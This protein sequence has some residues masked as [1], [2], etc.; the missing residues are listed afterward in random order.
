LTSFLGIYPNNGMCNLRY[1]GLG[2]FTL[3]EYTRS[4]LSQ[5][6]KGE[7][8]PNYGKTWTEERR[9]KH[10][11]TWKKKRETGESKRTLE[12]MEKFWAPTRRKYVITSADGQ[13]FETENLTSFCESKGWPLSAFR[14][15]LK[16]ENKTVQS[17]MTLKKRI[18]SVEGYKIDYV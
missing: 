10:Q 8:N 12:E 4:L 2:G 9:S 17:K 15:A 1:G 16:N 6:N 5:L 13:I 3:S 11:S 7:N 18:S 14:K